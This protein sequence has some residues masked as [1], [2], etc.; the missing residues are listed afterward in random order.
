MVGNDRVT[1]GYYSY[2][3]PDGK[4]YTV[5]Y[6]ADK[7]GYRATGSHLPVQ[8]SAARP[9]PVQPIGVQPIGVPPSPY[10]FISSTPGPFGSSTPGHYI[11]STPEPFSSTSAPFVSSTP[12]PFYSSTPT[13]FVSS[14]PSPFVSSSPYIS[15]PTPYAPQ[16]P[17][18]PSTPLY[19]RPYRPPYSGNVSKNQQFRF[20]SF[21]L[22]ISKYWT[23]DWT[24]FPSTTPAPSVSS[25][26]AYPSV[27]PFSNSAPYRQP[28]PIHSQSPPPFPGYRYTPPR[29]NDQYSHVSS[30]TPAPI[31]YSPS[32]EPPINRFSFAT[33]PSDR[34]VTTTFAPPIRNDLN[35]FSSTSR[36]P[37]FDDEP[38]IPFREYNPPASTPRP[39]NN[40]QP[41]QPNTVFITPKPFIGPS[42]VPN[43]LSINQDLVPPYLSV[44][45]LQGRREIFRDN[46]FPVEPI[47]AE[48]RPPGVAPI[49][50]TN[51]NY[52]KK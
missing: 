14:T 37:P 43:S 19:Q 1:T 32:R 46:G 39:F 27:S 42:R 20:F 23:I 47:R 11:S 31:F 49:T 7:Y 48:G 6:T 5:Y 16:T 34:R 8:E 10:P 38:Q 25:T 51:L 28:F 12:A 35:E 18:V 52:R 3:G 30:Q 45:P 4:I 13:P 40:I 33:S 9:T 22:E 24:G 2:V 21:I 50:I 29:I 15:S 17:F 44:G 26:S 36:P 41:D